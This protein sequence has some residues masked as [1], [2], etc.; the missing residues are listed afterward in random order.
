MNVREG[1]FVQYRCGER[2][3][4]RLRENFMGW[5]QP[6][7]RPALVTRVWMS[8]VGGPPLLSL[9]V[10]ADADPKYNEWRGSVPHRDVTTDP[11]HACWK[12]LEE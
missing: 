10:F 8:A 9:Q 7:W 1:D 12:G 11:T 2:G 5:E 4:E 3:D 6:V